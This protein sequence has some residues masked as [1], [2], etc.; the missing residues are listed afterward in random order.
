MS[1]HWTR[2]HVGTRGNEIADELAKEGGISG[3]PHNIN[4]PKSEIKAMI[5]KNHYKQWSEDWDEYSEARMTKFFYGRPDKNKAKYV[6]RLNRI[7]LSR[8]IRII[9]GHNSLF[10]FRNKIDGE[11][12]SICRFCLE[13]DETFIHLLNTCP[14]FNVQR[15]EIFLDKQISDNLE[16]RVDELLRFSEIPG[17]NNA[18]EGDT[19]LKWFDLVNEDGESESVEEDDQEGIG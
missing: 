6:C 3:I 14:R 5:Y 18:L 12:N 11:I 13:E 8:F 17:I 16:W 1:L 9:T 10:Y 7:K 2:A 15:K 4:L 19:S